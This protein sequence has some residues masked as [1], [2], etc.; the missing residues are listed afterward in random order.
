M[1]DY[2]AWWLL[3]GSFTSTP[4]VEL[5]LA[6][7]S[8]PPLIL[9][10][11][12]QCMPVRTLLPSSFPSFTLAWF[13]CFIG[14]YLNPLVSG[15]PVAIGTVFSIGAIAQ[16]IP[17]ITAVAIRVIFVRDNFRPGPWHLGKISRPCGLIALG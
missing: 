6:L 11:G 4:A 14:I 13:D 16:Y 7:V 1:F 9:G 12:L 8:G 10:Q 2:G 17:F 3:L 15:G 5:F